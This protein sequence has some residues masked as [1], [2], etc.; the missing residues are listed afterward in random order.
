MRAAGQVL[1][2]RSAEAVPRVLLMRVA[3]VL[4]PARALPP[5]LRTPSA[6]RL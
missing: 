6:Y 5:L 1:W 3:G 4:Q 2:Q